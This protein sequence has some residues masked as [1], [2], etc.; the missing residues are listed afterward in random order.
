MLQNLQYQRPTSSSKHIFNCIPCC[1]IFYG[2][3]VNYDVNDWSCVWMHKEKRQQRSSLS[4]CLCIIAFRL[5]SAART[6][7]FPPPEISM[8]QRALFPPIGWTPPGGVNCECGRLY[9]HLIYST[10]YMVY[11]YIYIHVVPYIWARAHIYGVWGNSLWACVPSGVCSEDEAPQLTRFQCYGTT[12]MLTFWN[13]AF[14]TLFVLLPPWINNDRKWKTSK[15]YY[16]TQTIT[17]TLRRTQYV[18]QQTPNKQ[19]WNHKVWPYNV[20][21]KCRRKISK[22]DNVTKK[23]KKNS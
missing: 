5:F 17:I 6:F 11:I 7:L 21:L 4:S 23:I 15:Y 1:C 2:N 20:W 8:T 16:D 10:I 13:Y 9:G 19:Y 3:C 12:F 22:L 14:S 18:F